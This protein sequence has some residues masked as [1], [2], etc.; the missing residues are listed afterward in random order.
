MMM[1]FEDDDNW[2]WYQMIEVLIDYL[3]VN[4]PFL[5]FSHIITFYTFI[6]TLAHIVYSLSP[7]KFQFYPS[8]DKHLETGIL[9][10]QYTDPVMNK[11]KKGLF[12]QW[13][14]S[15]RWATLWRKD[16]NRNGHVFK[17]SVKDNKWIHNWF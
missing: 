9:R 5:T 10:H 16:E 14:N 17:V 15:R 2:W 13:T 4:K 7:L 12:D 3:S 6:K 11:K 1:I 8:S